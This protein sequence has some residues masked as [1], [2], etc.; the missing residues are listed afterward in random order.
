MYDKFFKKLK[1]YQDDPKEFI[2]KKIW[3]D[4]FIALNKNFLQETYQLYKNKVVFAED[5][6]YHRY[7][8][9]LVD[10]LQVNQ[11]NENADIL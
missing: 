4:D 3:Y 6:I 11:Q 5:L 7:T 2:E 9:F 10:I 8:N 1:K